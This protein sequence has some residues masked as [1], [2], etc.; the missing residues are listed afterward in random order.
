MAAYS[1]KYACYRPEIQKYIDNFELV[2]E[3]EFDGDSNYDGD[4]WLVVDDYISDLI[5][6]RDE[7]LKKLEGVKG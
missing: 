1:Y 2:Y 4:Y 7:L 6:E 5:K 3:R